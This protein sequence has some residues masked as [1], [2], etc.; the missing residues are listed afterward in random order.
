MFQSK[1]VS[2]ISKFGIKG[3]R[4]VHYPNHDK[5]LVILLCG[6]NIIIKATKGK[7]GVAI[8][9]ARIEWPIEID[10]VIDPAHTNMSGMGFLKQKF[11]DFSQGKQTI[12]FCTNNEYQKSGGPTI[13]VCQEGKW[14]LYRNEISDEQPK[15][16]VATN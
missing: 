3:N 6:E 4:L 8:E 7:N 1:D 14:I 9:W 13:Y 2:C 10:I 16:H 15:S 5:T 11:R 12:I